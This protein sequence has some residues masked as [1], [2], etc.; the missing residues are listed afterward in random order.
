MAMMTS[1]KLMEEYFSDLQVLLASCERQIVDDVDTEMLQEL[2]E[3][4]SGLDRH[5][6][7]LKSAVDEVE[8][9]SDEKR[10]EYIN[11]MDRALETLNVRLSQIDP[12]E[13]VEKDHANEMREAAEILSDDTAGLMEDL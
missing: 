2:K 8:W 13:G 11:E 7:T 4:K 9:G 6:N 10:E 1:L 5:G 3:K 12:D